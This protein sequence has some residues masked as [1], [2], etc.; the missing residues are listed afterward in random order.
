MELSTKLLE[1]T[2]LSQMYLS[3]QGNTISVQGKA[4]KTDG[5]GEVSQLM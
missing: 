4:T 5:E 3:I 1:L 2:H